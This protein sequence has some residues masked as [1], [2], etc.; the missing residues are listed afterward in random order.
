VIDRHG[1]PVPNLAVDWTAARGRLQAA[2]S[3]ID[4]FGVAAAQPVF[5][6]LPGIYTYRAFAGGPD[7]DFTGLARLRPTISSGGASMQPVSNPDE[8]SL[9]ARTSPFTEGH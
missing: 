7:I 6:A 9:R 5:G 2:D 1:V 4:A 3:R 8:G